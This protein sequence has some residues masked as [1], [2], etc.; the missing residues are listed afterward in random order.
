MQLNCRSILNFV[1]LNQTF[2]K[3]SQNISIP[4]YQIIRSDRIG[5]AGGG[6]ALCIKKSIKVLKEEI[7]DHEPTLTYFKDFKIETKTF[8]KIDWK[9]LKSLLCSC[10]D[11]YP[12]IQKPSD[13][14]FSIFSTD[15]SVR[16]LDNQVLTPTLIEDNETDSSITGSELLESLKKL[17]SK[18][19]CGFDRISN[20]FTII[21]I[22]KKKTI[23]NFVYMALEALIL[24]NNAD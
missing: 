21:L 9:K 12:E 20:K 23:N 19:E 13:L 7:S 14:D 18:A 4:N 3:T 8:E 22:M 17:N 1:T 2:L 10:P 24:I 6:S 16:E 11:D 15:E 5:K